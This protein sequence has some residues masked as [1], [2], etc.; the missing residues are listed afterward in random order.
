VDPVSRIL[1]ERERRRAALVPFVI[2]AALLHSGAVAS[3]YLAGRL[4]PA[5]PAHLPGVSV[6]LIRPEPVP[7]RR[8]SPAAPSAPVPR[9]EPVTRPSPPPEPPPRQPEPSTRAS[10][11]AMPSAGSRA[12][13]GPTPAPA[14]RSSGRGLSLG[15][16]GAGPPAIPSD[17]QFTYYVDR[18]LGLIEQRWYKPHVPPGSRTR[19]R[20]TILRSGHLEGIG[21]EESSGIS[22]FDRAA[23]RA[24]YAANP[25]PPLPHGYTQGSLTIHLTFSE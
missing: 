14:A 3:V 16:A 21:I 7:A 9:P 2:L 24:I 13:P 22:S 15:D 12:T 25:L 23:L 19:V 18:M 10:A 4:R 8:R 17:F 20:F 5:R 1:L 11:D 6:R